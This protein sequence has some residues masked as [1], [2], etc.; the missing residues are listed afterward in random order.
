MAIGLSHEIAHGSLRLT[1][2][3]SNTESDVGYLVD[4][5]EEIVARLRTMSPLYEDFVKANKQAAK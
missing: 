2:G 1:F 5:L 4:C 3:E